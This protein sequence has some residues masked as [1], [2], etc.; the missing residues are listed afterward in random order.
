MGNCCISQPKTLKENPVYY[1]TITIKIKEKDLRSR[2]ITFEP[3]TFTLPSPII[4]TTDEFQI[5]NCHLKLSACVLPN[6]DPRGLVV[7][8]CQDNFGYACLDGMLL[9]IMFDGHGKYGKQ[10][11]EFCNEFML[12][13][14]KTHISEFQSN[15][16]SS[17]STLIESC[18]LDLRSNSSIDCHLSGTCAILLLFSSDY[19]HIASVGDLRAVIGTTSP[20]SPEE[21]VLV[22]ENPY[23]RLIEPDRTIRSFALSVDQKPEHEQEF[24][25]ITESGGVVQQF[26]NFFGMKFGPFRVFD[27]KGNLP[28]LTLSR[29]IGDELGK[30][31]GIIS[32]PACNTFPFFDSKD[33]FVI[34]GSDGLWDVMENIEAVNFVE[35]FRKKA[36]EGPES[37]SDGTVNLKNSQIAKVLAEEARYRWLGLCEEDDVVIDDISCAILEISCLTPTGKMD[38]I[39]R[40]AIQKSIRASIQEVKEFKSGV[41]RGDLIR[42]SFVPSDSLEGSNLK[43]NDKFLN[44]EIG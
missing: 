37:E 12:R 1:K 25:R 32:E 10:V 22:K 41:L 29:S 20:E 11:V 16:K 6:I 5:E 34:V 36:K 28:G 38:N 15:P 35:R 18:D 42:G 21:R 40:K 4:S 3:I 17:L 7:K 43:L 27:Q 2:T 44:T 8:E 19:F 33:L 14:F 24:T 39:K 13:Y 26:S 9:L 23:F 31:I 30:S